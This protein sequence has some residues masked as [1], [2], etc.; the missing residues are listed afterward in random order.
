M[1]L[2]MC[3]NAQLR[4]HLAVEQQILVQAGFASVDRT[5][6]VVFLV[7]HVVRGLVC[8]ERRLRA[9]DKHP[10]LIVMLLTTSVNVRQQ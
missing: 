10:D 6:H 7:K 1:Q 8:V 9:L 5:T 2:I 4:L 3:V